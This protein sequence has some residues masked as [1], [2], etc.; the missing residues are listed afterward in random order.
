MIYTRVVFVIGTCPVASDELRERARF[1]LRAPGYEHC[2]WVLP[3]TY[4]ASRF[5]QHLDSVGHRQ[6]RKVGD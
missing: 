1:P 6:K 5:L 3:Q 2:V 4:P